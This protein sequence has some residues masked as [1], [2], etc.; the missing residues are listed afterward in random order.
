MSISITYGANFIHKDITNLALSTCV[1][2]GILSIPACDHK[3]SLIFSDTCKNFPKVIHITINGETTVYPIN[4]PITLDVSTISLDKY[5]L[6]SNPRSWFDRS[7]N[8]LKQLQ[9]I[10]QNL[11]LKYGSFADEFY[12]QLMAI[13]YINPNANVLEIGG[14]IGRN[15]LVIATILYNQKNLVT[16]ESSP[17]HFAELADN[18]AINGYEFNIEN[19][20]LSYKRLIQNKD[21]TIPSEDDREGFFSVNCM[22]YQEIEEKF[23]I[24]FDTLVADCEGALYYIFNDYPNML[25]NIKMIIMENDYVDINHK[26]SV[27]KILLEKGFK[28]ELYSGGNISWGPCIYNFYE[29]WIRK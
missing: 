8:P 5:K 17:I 20:A 28:L 9:L 3:R 14:N 2:D 22:T 15:S 24:K 16:L 4:S 12:E 18:K 29:V 19:S 7:A 6:S 1:T 23:N 21:I 11:L 26:L 13:N 25:D 27:N 10:Q